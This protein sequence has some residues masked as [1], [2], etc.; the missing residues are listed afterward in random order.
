MEGAFTE[1]NVGT[2]YPR[3]FDEAYNNVTAT[4]EM[5]DKGELRQDVLCTIEWAK[6][7]NFQNDYDSIVPNHQVAESTYLSSKTILEFVISVQRGHY[8]KPSDF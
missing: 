1:R 5:I 4:I 2:D 8:V 6:P 3:N 7:I